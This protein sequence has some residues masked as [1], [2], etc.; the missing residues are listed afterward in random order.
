MRSKLTV[1][2]IAL[3]VGACNDQPFSPMAE[4]SLDEVVETPGIEAAAGH[5]LALHGATVGYYRI[6][7]GAGVADQVG[8]ITAAGETAVQLTNLTAADLAG[9]NVL[10]IDNPSNGSYAGGGGEFLA[11]QA[12][13]AAFV[14]AGGYM[15]FHDRFVTP[16]ET[17][18]PGGASFDIRRDFGDPRDINVRD[19]STLVTNGPGGIVTNTTLDGGTASSHGF[20]VVGTLPGDAALILTRSDPDELVTFS[21]C[22]GGGGVVYSSIPLDFYLMGFGP[23]VVRSNM[24]NIYA[25]NTVAYAA[26][27][28]CVLQVG[29]DIWP[30]RDPNL[31]NPTK[32]SP[33]RVAILGSANFDVADVDV[34]TLAFGPGGAPAGNDHILDDVNG[35]GFPDLVSRYNQRETGLVPGDTEACIAGATIAGTPIE[36][37]DAVLV[38]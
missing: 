7:S 11:N 30:G 32:R 5:T 26:E 19:G 8:P 22:F 4:S 18:L 12:A 10:F 25:P 34:T 35:D 2:A 15:V 36:G 6:T 21:Y 23:P 29:I 27:G 17:V 20:A 33:V 31:I 13:I 24:V 3:I 28:F 16:A 1:L 9:I 37:C 38:P 14:S